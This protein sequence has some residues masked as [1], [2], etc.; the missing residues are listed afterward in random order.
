MFNP[1]S[2]P[3]LP[4]FNVR[5]EDVAPGFRVTP[6]PE[7][8]GFN[9]DDN[10]LPRPDPFRPAPAPYP[11][12][13]PQDPSLSP[14]P[15]GSPDQAI[16]DWL[17]TL[18]SM[19]LP[20][21]S[22]PPGVRWSV[23]EGLLVKPVSDP[24][25]EPFGMPGGPEAEGNVPPQPS[26]DA[27]SYPQADAAGD[28]AA[29]AN[30]PP[31]WPGSSGSDPNFILANAD[32]DSVQEAQQQRPLPQNQP[33]PQTKPPVPPA[34]G[35][36]K[37]PAPARVPEKPGMEMT[38]LERRREQE[39]ADLNRQWW[40]LKE[41]DRRKPIWDQL[42]RTSPKPT[43]SN[44]EFP[45]LLP[46][47][48]EE[49]L[50]T[51]I[52]PRYAAWTRAAAERY[53]IPP[54]LLA[55]L[56]YQESKYKADAVSPNGKAIGIAQLTPVAVKALGLDPK[57]FIYRDPK[58]SIDAGAAYLAQR[59]RSLKNWPKAVAA[60]NAGEGAVTGWLA[61]YGRDWSNVPEEQQESWWKEMNAHLKAVFRGQP[62][63]F[64]R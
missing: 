11:F 57:T 54:T 14:P 40:R 24:A 42:S 9:L 34:A 4:G 12:G 23:P 51:K 6:P 46:D 16:P 47:N 36:T 52:D 31:P 49:F 35:Q 28:Q 10:G 55:R 26:E 19:P 38:E 22:A 41:A 37:P 3:K 33:R 39:F 25:A 1:S 32:G 44:N 50:T 62:E 56:L 43:S 48:W 27:Q 13:L 60:Y 63:Q 18:L 59:Y 15:L 21:P 5:P 7:T 29:P 8:I 53:G 20:S 30:S 61:G 58:S 17:H 2:R 45:D 64:D